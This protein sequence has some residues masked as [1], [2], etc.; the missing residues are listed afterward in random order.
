MMTIILFSSWK[1]SLDHHCLAKTHNWHLIFHCRKPSLK[2][3]FTCPSSKK[4][5]TGI[6]ACIYPLQGPYFE[7]AL[8]NL[9]GHIQLMSL[10]HGLYEIFFFDQNLWAVPSPHIN[11]KYI[12]HKKNKYIV[13]DLVYKVHFTISYHTSRHMTPYDTSYIYACEL[14]FYRWIIWIHLDQPFSS[15]FFVLISWKSIH[16]LNYLIQDLASHG[17]THEPNHDHLWVFAVNLILVIS[18]S[19]HEH[20]IYHLDS[21]LEFNLNASKFSSFAYSQS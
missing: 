18:S 2:H 15:S 3:I 12:I 17:S 11:T 6:Q 19:L 1:C 10:S 4:R 16:H 8:L 14:I 21:F 9:D 20:H 7:L 5:W 13:H